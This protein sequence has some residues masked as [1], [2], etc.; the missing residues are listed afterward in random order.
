MRRF[1]GLMLAIALLLASGFGCKW[2]NRG[3]SNTGP[4]QTTATPTPN[5]LDAEAATAVKEFWEAHYTRCGDSYYGLEDNYPFVVLH[6][7]KGVSFMARGAGPTSEADKLNGILWNGNV[8]IFSG[9]Y[10]ERPQGREWSNWKQSQNL[11]EEVGATKR[12]SGGW[13]V[14]QVRHITVVK[15][16]NCSEVE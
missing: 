9:P 7:Y 6:Q 12:T 10:R 2:S 14:T 16:V 1:S 11:V 13:S 5:S 4:E 8:R 15:K 3:S